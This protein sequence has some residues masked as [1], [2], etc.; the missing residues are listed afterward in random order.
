VH[1]IVRGTQPQYLF[2]LLPWAVEYWPYDVT[3]VLAQLQ[4]LFFSALAFVWLNKM[5][6]Y[7]PELRSVNIDT[8]WFYRKLLPATGRL[9]FRMMTS[10]QSA[11]HSVVTRSFE[12]FAK[13]SRLSKVL[14]MESWPTG[15]M[16]FWIAVILGTYLI[17]QAFF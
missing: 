10:I 15:S 11:M 17:L 16:V 5:N 14:L 12:Y 2:A 1:C 9:G 13:D 3:H 8:E 7:P 6:L 4:I